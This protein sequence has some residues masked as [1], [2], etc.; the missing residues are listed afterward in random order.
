MSLENRY[1]HVK[2]N[3][4]IALFVSKRLWS[5]RMQRLYALWFQ[6]LNPK[7]NRHYFQNW[8]SKVAGCYLVL[9]RTVSLAW[10]SFSCKTKEDNSDIFLVFC[11]VL[12]FC[13]TEKVENLPVQIRMSRQKWN[14]LYLLQCLL[15]SYTCLP[16]QHLFWM[17]RRLNNQ[18]VNHQ[19][20]WNK[21][22]CTLKHYC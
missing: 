14:Y 11:T 8:I 9:A 22:T 19:H 12:A 7:M 6:Y 16:Q 3:R 18:I 2:F 21:S 13:Y 4:Y 20:I 1:P 5:D 10:S 17:V 15:T